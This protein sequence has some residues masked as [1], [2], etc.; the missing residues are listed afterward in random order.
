MKNAVLAIA[1]S[2]AVHA[3]LAA[4]VAAYL[5]YAPAPEALASLDLSSVELSFAEIDVDAPAVAAMPPSQPSRRPPR[6]EARPPEAP[7]PEMS[8][9]PIGTGDPGVSPPED[10]A[11][12]MEESSDASEAA[13]VPQEAPQQA[14]ID[15]PPRPQRAI[16]P[17]YP[18]GARQRGEQGDVHLEIRVDEDGSVGDVKVVGSSGSGELDAAALRAVRA[19]RFV[20]AKSGGKAVS[21]AARLVLRFRLRN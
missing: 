2:V 9:V 16:R 21:S 6:P 18:P 20:P 10:E 5:A 15:A 12:P 11:V 19:A 7:Q 1:A 8:P 3:L 14:R 17:Y 4:A 13:P